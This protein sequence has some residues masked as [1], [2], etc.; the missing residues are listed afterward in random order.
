MLRHPAWHILLTILV[1]IPK[2]EL[3]KDYQE[4]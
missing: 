3:V 1:S 4:H 2:E